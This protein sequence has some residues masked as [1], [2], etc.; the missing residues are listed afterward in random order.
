VRWGS[1]RARR[2]LASGSPVKADGGDV[3]GE[4]RERKKG[5]R[6][7]GRWADSGKDLGGGGMLERG[8]KEQSG[9]ESG[10]AADAF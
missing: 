10:T 4:I 3:S 8:A 5:P 7:R 2:G 9:E 6:V 1:K